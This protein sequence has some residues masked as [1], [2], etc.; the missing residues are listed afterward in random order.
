MYASPIRRVWAKAAKEMI[1]TRHVARDGR[2]G[3]GL[4]D[5]RAAS[6]AGHRH[7]RPHHR[8]GGRADARG[9]AGLGF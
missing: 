4:V 5:D 6:I 3:P 2:P 9:P 8:A 7:R 1:E